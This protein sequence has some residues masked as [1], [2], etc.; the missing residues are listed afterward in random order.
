MAGL[1]IFF[2]VLILDQLAKHIV[3]STMMLGQSIPVIPG[4]FHITY[5][6]NPGA[7]FGIL[8]DARW[9][10]VAVAFVMFAFFLRY[11]SWLKEQSRLLR[12]GCAAMLSGA[13]GNMI[14]R[15]QSGFVVDFFD[16]RIWP[17][18]NIADI[19]IVLGVA[20]MIVAMFSERKERERAKGGSRVWQKR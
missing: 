16:F 19:A 18:F 9:F 5:I 8:A 13:I 15:V 7:A 10:F 2:G 20:G 1:I 17:I 4:I 11:Y 14:D 12:Y 6:L 3:M